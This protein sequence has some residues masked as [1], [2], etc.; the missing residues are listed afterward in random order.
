MKLYSTIIPNLT[1][2]IYISLTITNA[3][4]FHHAFF[5]ENANL[6][7]DISNY[8]E[9]ENQRENTGELLR[10]QHTQ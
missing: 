6:V 7:K 5:R 9:N 2:S 3:F 1:H 4:I 10:V 8:F